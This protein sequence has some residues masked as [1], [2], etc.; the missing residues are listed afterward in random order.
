MGLEKAI[1][2][3]KE[4][5]KPHRQSKVFDVTCR[6]HGSC[7]WCRRGRLHHCIREK[8]NADEQIREYVDGGAEFNW[9]HD[10]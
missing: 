2:S 8:M 5:R 1:D 6:N 7:P 3:G 4:R 9:R 10:K